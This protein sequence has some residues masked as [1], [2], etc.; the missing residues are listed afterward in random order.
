MAFRK[1]LKYPSQDLLKKSSV[2]TEIDDKIENIVTDLRDTINVA[3]G[4]GLS[5]PQIGFHQRVIYVACPAFTSEM[6][7]PVIKSFDCIQGM[8][9]GCLSFPGVVETLPRY[10]KVSVEFTK[11]DGTS[12]TLE[13]EGLPAQV[14]Q[15][16]VEHL[17]G[18]LMIHKLSRLKRSRAISRVKKVRSEVDSILSIDDEKKITRTRKNAHLSSKEIKIRRRRR[19]QNR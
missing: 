17:D 11:L 6:I 7:N 19:K 5:A 1:I 18:K 4:V 15:H 13:L 14:V 2:V 8:E 3:G 16:E 10:S 12:Q 9:E